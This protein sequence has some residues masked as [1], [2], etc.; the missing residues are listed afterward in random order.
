MRTILISLLTFMFPLWAF[1]QRPTSVPYDDGPLNVFESVES[2]IFYIVIPIVIITLYVIWRIRRRNE[3]KREGGKYKSENASKKTD[4]K[5]DNKHVVQ[6]R[7]IDHV[8]HDTLRVV[9]EKPAGYTFSPGQATDIAINKNGWQNER[10][11]FTFTSLPGDPYLEFIIKTYPE[12]DGATDKLL[13]VKEGDEL[14]LHEVFGAITYKGEGVFIAGGAGITPFISIF[15]D[16]SKK[17]KIGN[18]FL[19]FAN[20]TTA[21]IILK[22][23][24]E[25]LLSDSVVHILSEEET[26]EYEYG[27]IS[28]DF[29]KDFME[30]DGQYFYICGPPA[31]M[32]AVES[33]LSELDVAK[34]K[35]VKESW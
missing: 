30:D 25:S 20:K 5:M 26:E 16:L 1:A 12:H 28:K 10:R 4:N 15:R 6:I 2:I 11:P 33:Q 27:L 34:D 13:E 31:M 3:K 24:L 21:D 8:T 19:I 22:D 18:N 32:D 9:T 23:E 29:I 35:I 7:S 14:I 17:N